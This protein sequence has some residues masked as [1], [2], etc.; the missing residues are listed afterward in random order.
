MDFNMGSGT[1][2]I[3]NSHMAPGSDPDQRSCACPY[4]LE[5]TQN[6]GLVILFYAPHPILREKLKLRSKLDFI[7]IDLSYRE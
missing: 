5:N 6:L 4:L 1:V 2:Q 7:F 3:M